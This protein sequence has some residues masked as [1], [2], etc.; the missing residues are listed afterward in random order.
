MT[1]MLAQTKRRIR[2]NVRHGALSALSWKADR[3]GR[4][5]ELLAKPRVHFAYLHGVPVHEEPRFRALLD[6]VSEQHDLVS[7]SE[8][9]RRLRSG[10]VSRPTLTFSFDDAF[11]SN[12]RTAAI[13]EE[14]G[15][16]G[17]FFIPAGFPGT[18]TLEQARAFFGY[19]QNIT[20]P[21]MSWRQIEELSAR[22]HE[23]GNHT[24]DHVNLGSISSSEVSQQVHEATRTLTSRMG[25]CQHFA[26]PFGRW[27][28]IR[29]D[30]VAAVF[31]QG[32]E[33]CASAERGSHIPMQT[34]TDGPM[35]LLRE[36]LMTAWPL[37]HNLYF[38]AQGAQRPVTPFSDYPTDE[39]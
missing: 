34:P 16:V 21:A 23:I 14:Y 9:V 3:D 17:T 19:S 27:H 25:H 20:E 39:S 35:V 1:T 37:E 38:L 5:R 26:W 7:H 2:V 24:V 30:G 36:H 13:L 22:G 18:A 8:A 33:T 6:V 4:I 28:H 31:D 15:T 29:P 12:Y 32:Y 11:A 10:H